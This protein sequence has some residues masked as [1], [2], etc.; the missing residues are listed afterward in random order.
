MLNYQIISTLMTNLNLSSS[1]INHYKSLIELNNKSLNIKPMNI[2]K[3]KTF[4][5]LES[6]YIPGKNR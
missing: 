2:T 4:S 6:Q 3:L 5:H 1:V